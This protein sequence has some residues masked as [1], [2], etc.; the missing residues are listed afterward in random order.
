MISDTQLELFA[1]AVLKVLEANNTQ[2][3]LTTP[4]IR[5]I[6]RQFAFNPSEDET[7][8]A[9]EY[10]SGKRLVEAAPKVLVKINRAWKITNAGR[11][12]LDDH[13]L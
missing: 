7:I 8:N 5:L 6:I 12:Y 4:A 11:Q 9:L 10:L 1:N 13:N 3:G 2:F